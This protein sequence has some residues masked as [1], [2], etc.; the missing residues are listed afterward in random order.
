MSHIKKISVLKVFVFCFVLI[1]TGSFCFPYIY[2]NGSTGGYDQNSQPPGIQGN[3]SMEIL[4]IEGAGYF[5]QGHAKVQT[6]LNIVEL[7]DIKSID[8]IELKKLVKCALI[9]IISA[10][11]SFE[12]L[13]KSAESTP[14]NLDVIE[15]LNK[16]DYETFMKENGLNPFIFGMVRDYLVA[17]DITG[18]YKYAYGNFTEI[19]QLLLKIQ[20]SVVENRLPELEI[21]WRVNELCAGETL[22][23]SYIAR[24]FKE[25]K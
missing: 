10:R 2:Y 9:K 20:S 19:E 16:F 25:M 21:F 5:Y 6:L 7:Q 13:I 4:V 12:E 17:G 1:I 11:L 8:Y 14:Y 15:K 3:I 23:G 22:F 18:T 24:V